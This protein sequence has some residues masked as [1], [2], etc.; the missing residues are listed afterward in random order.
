[1]LTVTEK[2]LFTIKSNN[3]MLIDVNNLVKNLLNIKKLYKKNIK[4]KVLLTFSY[5]MIL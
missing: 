5:I 3:K 1:M 4:S 2:I